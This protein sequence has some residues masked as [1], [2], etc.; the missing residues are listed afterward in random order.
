MRPITT[1][2]RSWNSHLDGCL[3][4]AFVQYNFRAHGLQG[5]L[6]ARQARLLS[7][8]GAD[9]PDE[10]RQRPSRYASH[11]QDPTVSRRF[12]RYTGASAFAVRIGPYSV[13]GGCAPVQPDSLSNYAPYKSIPM[14]EKPIHLLHT[15]MLAISTK[16]QTPR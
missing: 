7:T 12:R 15:H 6:S 2:L 16:P 8:Q 5:P 10:K 14:H 13:V 4:A 1:Q 3:A 11:T 9:M